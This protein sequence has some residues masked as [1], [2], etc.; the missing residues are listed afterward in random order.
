[1]ESLKARV[2]NGRLVLDVPTSLPEGTEIELAA[3]DP[4]DDLDDEQRARLHDAIDRG[5]D[6]LKQGR[7]IPAQDVIDELKRKR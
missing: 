6:E 7:G 4:D 3:S 1:M 5:I 2:R